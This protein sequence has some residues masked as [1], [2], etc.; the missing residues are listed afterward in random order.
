VGT[1]ADGCS[2]EYGTGEEAGKAGTDSYCH[3]DS[4]PSSMSLLA[5]DED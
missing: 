3:S 4:S 5:L 1:A 2:P